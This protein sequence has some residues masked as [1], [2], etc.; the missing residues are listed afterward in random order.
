MTDET[1]PIIK[2]ENVES[3][4]I[5]KESPRI[6][7]ELLRQKKTEALDYWIDSLNKKAKVK[8]NHKGVFM[9]IVSSNREMSEREKFMRLYK[10]CPIPDDERMYNQF[11]FIS[12][13]HC[14]RFMFLW[15]L[16]QKM[17]PVHGIIAEFGV[18]WGGNMAIYESLHGIYEP[19]NYNRK[20]LGFD[21][22]TGFPSID[23][24]DGAHEA[25]EMA[26]TDDYDLY[27][28]KILHYHETESPLS[29][30]QRYRLI[31][32]DI[33]TTLPLYL[34]KHPET[35]FAAAIP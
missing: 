35:W 1:R 13:Q 28:D 6:R 18:R 12:R 31:K 17:L 22:F 9:E 20:I 5:E 19:Y 26:L 15:E 23:S 4:P 29:Q 32:G 2:E 3:S 11:L 14:M 7:D 8:I 16:Y 25:G 34:K 10:E 30:I 24:K 21:T 33:C 27:L